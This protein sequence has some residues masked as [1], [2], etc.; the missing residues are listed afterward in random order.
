MPVNPQLFLFKLLNHV[1]VI[2]F[3]ISCKNRFQSIM[4]KKLNENP[5][6]VEKTSCFFSNLT[7]DK[8]IMSVLAKTN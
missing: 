1:V 4:L 7:E 2:D 6:I 5:M 8:D 3:A